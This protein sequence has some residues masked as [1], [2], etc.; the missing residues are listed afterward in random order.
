[1]ARYVVTLSLGGSAECAVSREVKRGDDDRAILFAKDWLHK[2][3]LSTRILWMWYDAYVIKEVTDNGEERFIE[4]G[5]AEERECYR[6]GYK[7]GS[8]KRG[9]KQSDSTGSRLVPSGQAKG[10]P[11]DTRADYLPIRTLGRAKSGRKP[12]E[13]SPY[14]QKM[15]AM[16]AAAKGGQ[17]GNGDVSPMGSNTHSQG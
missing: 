1:M 14:Q 15:M 3:R 7:G 4:E 5:H 10:K 17:L 6:A 9:S 16:V 2:T 8:R 13:L 11:A 12:R